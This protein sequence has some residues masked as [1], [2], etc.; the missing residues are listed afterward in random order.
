MALLTR[1][2]LP[3]AALP[4]E[5]VDCPALGGSLIVRG[6]DMPGMLHW[7]AERRRLA[8]P[9][10]GED[11]E[12]ARHRAGAQLIPLLLSLAV[13]LEDGPAYTAAQWAAIGA[14]HPEDAM[15]LFQAALRLSGQDPDAEKKT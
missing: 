13:H 15:R 11:E 7:S 12:A 9:Q 8:E 3:P 10:A 1:A 4:T 6:L 5:E 14:R 2:T